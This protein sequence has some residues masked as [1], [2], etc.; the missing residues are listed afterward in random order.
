M[1]PVDLTPLR[2]IAGRL[3]KASDAFN[4][5]IADLDEQFAEMNIGVTAWDGSDKCFSYDGGWLLA[6]NDRCSYQAGDAGFDER[7]F[8][9][10]RIGY[11]KLSDGWGL[12]AEAVVVV[13]RLDEN[14]EP[15]GEDVLPIGEPVRLTQAPR[16]V[17]IEAAARLEN[18][19]TRLASKADKF[20]ADIESARKL[21]T[22]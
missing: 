21:V 4:D 15:V 14:N 9:G 19:L 11:T 1:V 8:P 6:N 2:E 10:W 20:V 17:R 22:D 18:L 5:L 12:A 3:N 7:E 13:E 16:A